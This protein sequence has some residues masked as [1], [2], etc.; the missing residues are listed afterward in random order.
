MMFI[1]RSRIEI[2]LQLGL[3]WN[4]IEAQEWKFNGLSVCATPRVTVV[5]LCVCFK[6]LAATYLVHTSKTQSS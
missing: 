2:N 5:I 4:G 3:N 1:N 6:T